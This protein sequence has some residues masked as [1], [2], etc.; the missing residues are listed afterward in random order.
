[1]RELEDKIY[2]TIIDN[3]RDKIVCVKKQLLDEEN[4]FERHQEKITGFGCEIIQDLNKNL[5]DTI[6]IME[7]TLEYIKTYI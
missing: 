1:M 3:L 2:F 4:N 5:E 6:P 7:K